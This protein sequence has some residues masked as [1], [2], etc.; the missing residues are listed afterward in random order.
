[1]SEDL[2]VTH[3]SYCLPGCLS[4]HSDEP[5][6]EGNDNGCADC[7]SVYGNDYTEIDEDTATLDGTYDKAQLLH[8]ASHL[9][10][11]QSIPFRGH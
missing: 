2:P 8:I 7:G 6:E 9:L 10:P 1:M 5:L 3:L 11:K 4:A